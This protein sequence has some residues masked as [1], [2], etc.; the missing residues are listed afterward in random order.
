[1]NKAIF[2]QKTPTTL[3]SFG[4]LRL[5]HVSDD[6]IALKEVPVEWH[7][8]DNYLQQFARCKKGVEILHN[9]VISVKCSGVTEVVR[10]LH[11]ITGLLISP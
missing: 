3:D 2:C 4:P 11:T 7:S 10:Q 9:G 5:S 8:G 1:M 6:N